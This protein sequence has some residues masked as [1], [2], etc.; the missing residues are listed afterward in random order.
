MAAQPLKQHLIDPDICIRCITCE[1]TCPVHAVTHD[2]NNYVV[3]AEICG[4][5][6]KCITPCPTGAIDNWRLVSKPYTT[7]EQFA[8]KE[9]P[10]ETA[11][12]ET[13]PSHAEA[14][15]D[16]VS[17][18]LDHA[19]K[20]SGTSPRPPASAGKPTIN[21]YNRTKPAQAKVVGN[22]RLT[23]PNTDHDIRHIILDFGSL[24]M[25]VL[26]GQSLGI[27]PSGAAA[28][29]AAHKVRLYSISS[30]REGEK[31]NA[32]NVAFTVKRVPGGV[33]SNYVC[34]LDSGA[35]STSP[36]RS[37]RPT[38]CRTSLPRTSSRSAPALVPPP[39]GRSSNAADAQCP[40][41][42]AVCCFS[43]APAFLGQHLCFSRAPDQP[44]TYVQDAI[45]RE[46]ELVGSLLAASS[47]HVFVCGLKIL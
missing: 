22:F 38:G 16:D 36:A 23:A 24:S 2:D 21:L 30:P 14:L 1:E 29:G 6:M 28:S 42:P 7:E 45:R 41:P 8:W 13:T 11:A 20:G 5:C 44:K 12:T 15:E 46:S 43:S 25:P 32:D 27:I 34:D 10:P 40:R 17:E 18:L 39:S 37:G 9:L 4:R 47:T 3:K 33:C 19:H 26:E 31:L 35:S